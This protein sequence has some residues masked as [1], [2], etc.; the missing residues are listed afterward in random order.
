M[1]ITAPILAGYS[2]GDIALSTNIESILTSL[3][4]EGH[5]VELSTHNNPG[6]LLH[7]YRIDNGLMTVNTDEHG[8]IIS[9]SCQPPYQGTYAGKLWPGMSVAQIKAVTQKQ[10]LIFSVLVLDNEWGVCFDLPPPYDEYDYIHEL[11]DKLI[12][13]EIIVRHENWRGY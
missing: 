3:Y 10:M 5:K 2:V 8:V 6:I 7:S 12:L 9:L 4:S 1:N 13:K 11:P